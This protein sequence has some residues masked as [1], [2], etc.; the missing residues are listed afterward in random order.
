MTPDTIEQHKRPRRFSPRS[1]IFWILASAVV[2]VVRFAVL[3]FWDS[4]RRCPEATA[5]PCRED[6][7]SHARTR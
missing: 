5:L 7:G 6:V 4:L 2:V 3:M 1:A